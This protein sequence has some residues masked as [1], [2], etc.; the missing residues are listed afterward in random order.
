MTVYATLPTLSD[1]VL[2][3]CAK[4]ERSP[5]WKSG[6]VPPHRLPIASS[7][8]SD[9]RVAGSRASCVSTHSRAFG[10]Q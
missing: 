3:P 4:I 2:A 10:G 6:D 8:T 1:L 5:K 7:A 9:D